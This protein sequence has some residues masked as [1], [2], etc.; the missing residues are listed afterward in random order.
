MSQEQPDINLSPKDTVVEK[1][2]SGT[3]FVLCTSQKGVDMRWTHDSAEH[4]T[5]TKG[6]YVTSLSGCPLRFLRKVTRWGEY[7]NET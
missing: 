1:Y 4:I 7:R 3:H 2:V 5:A 6:R